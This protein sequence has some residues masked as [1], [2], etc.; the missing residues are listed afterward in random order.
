MSVFSPVR[1]LFILLLDNIRCS[2]KIQVT[3]RL[4]ICLLVSI[5]LVNYLRKKKYQLCLGVDTP[6][7]N[8]FSGWTRWIAEHVGILTGRFLAERK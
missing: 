8:W 5:I 3:Y 1:S 2:I 6:N 7:G 4:S